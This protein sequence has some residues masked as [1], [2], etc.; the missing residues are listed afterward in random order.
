MTGAKHTDARGSLSYNNDLDLTQVKRMYV[1]ENQDTQVLRAWQGHKKE[2][3]WFMVVKGSFKIELIA[4]DN[5]EKP[6]KKPDKYSF[7]LNAENLNVLY[8]PAGYV[9]SIQSLEAASNCWSW[10]I[11]CWVNIRT[12]IDL[13]LIILGNLLKIRVYY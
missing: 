7:M 2:Q 6:S 13:Q 11:I 3:R 1:I 8:V 10:L 5:W 12:I 4:I 9:N